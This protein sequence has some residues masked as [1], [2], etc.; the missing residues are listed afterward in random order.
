MIINAPKKLTFTSSF[1]FITQFSQAIEDS[2][3]II[4][5][6]SQMGW[7]TPGGMVLFAAGIRGL[8]Y[9]C[10]R[11]SR[12]KLSVRGHDTCEYPR[13]IGFFHA[14]G[15]D[16]EQEP[17]N[18]SS[19]EYIPVTRRNIESLI[20]HGS[21]EEGSIHSKVEARAKQVA[22]VLARGN[23]ELT[24][25]LEYCLREMFRNIFEHSKTKFCWY[26]GQY[27]PS[28]D[29]VDFAFA[30]IGIGLLESLNRH[31]SLSVKTDQEAVELALQAG[32]TGQPGK[33][34][35]SE[36][37][38]PEY[39][40]SGYGLYIASELVRS[41]GKFSIHSKSHGITLLGQNVKK[42]EGF[43]P[44]T[45]VVLSINPSKIAGKSIKSFVTD[46]TKTGE[47]VAAQSKLPTVKKA[48]RSSTL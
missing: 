15:V 34:L 7:A 12:P 47:S 1:D 25:V 17:V 23:E 45:A 28:K 24:K 35:W 46:I 43:F 10:N 33:S 3:H 16:D 4:I 32:I 5:D 30:D 13:N 41:F 37:S 6:F 26:C 2:D 14:I 39:A 31:P 18:Y 8:L 27:W 19:S 44:G 20:K 48:S 40:N 36:T 21:D 22:S 9:Q 29:R 42:S 38:G 11:V